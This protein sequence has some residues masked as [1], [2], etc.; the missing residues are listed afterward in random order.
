MSDA[1]EKIWA[2]PPTVFDE[3]DVW[4]TSETDGAIEYTRTDVAE[5]RIKELEAALEGVLTYVSTSREAAQRAAMERHDTPAAD[6]AS[7]ARA[8]LKREYT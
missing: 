8:A 1:P 4:Q 5:A 2:H 7:V 6:A 3:W